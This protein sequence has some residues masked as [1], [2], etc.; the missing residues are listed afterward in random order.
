MVGEGNVTL[1]ASGSRD[2]DGDP[3][4][5]AFSWS[6]TP[7]RYPLAG[8]LYPALDGYSGCQAADGSAALVEQQTGSALALQL[9]GTPAG[10][11]YT[12]SLTV[13]KGDRVAT[14]SVWLVVRAAV[15]LPVITVQALGAAKVNPA[16]KLTLRASVSSFFP[17]TLS[18]VWSVVS[19]P[20]FTGLL[21]LPGVAATPLSSQSLVINAGS[22]PPRQTVVFRLSASDRGGSSAAEIAVPVSGAPTGVGGRPL[23]DISV[24]P[25]SGFGL[26]TSFAVTA[27]GWFEG[28]DGPLQY[29][30]QYT[31]AGVDAPP[32][33]L[34][35]FRPQS[36][37]AGVQLP[38]G[39]PAG[40]GVV[41]VAVV[42][43]NAFGATAVS[44]PA[45]VKVVWDNAVLTDP[46][47][48]SAL[49]SQQAAD[50]TSKVLTGNPDAALAAV[51]GLSALLN[52]EPATG[53]RRRRSAL[54]HRSARRS[55]LQEAE[56]VTAEEAMRAEHR[57]A[58]LGLVSDVVSISLPETSVRIWQSV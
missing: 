34:L 7:P 49:V 36:S 38:A 48:Q 15:R 10:A 35:D 5:L 39:D 50:A 6:C 13:S 58:L 52:T 19:P 31:V 22:L 4:A 29:A 17:D 40:G 47:A 11:N 9:L 1:D 24:S 25:S 18:T 45:A 12:L 28:D 54:R 23:G 56:P 30:F 8:A 43:R 42:V 53:A 44:A 14:T 27:S 33:A 20:E 3:G 57:G 26:N 21:A 2:P 51:S 16:A 37:A 46:A 55:L 32:V 41:N